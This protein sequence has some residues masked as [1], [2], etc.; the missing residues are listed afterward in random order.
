DLDP[1]VPYRPLNWPDFVLD[2]PDRLDFAEPAY[3]VGGAVRDALWNQPIHDLDLTVPNGGIALA[4]RIANTFN[5]DFFVLDS[6][7]DVG[8]ALV[9]TEWGRIT[10]DVARFRGDDLQAD[11]LDR[12]FTINAMAV[13]LS[14]DLNLLIDP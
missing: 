8:R 2:L 10:I 3:L 6:E 14:Q 7:R 11:L 5:G 13:D 4:K 1:R 9:E 12:D